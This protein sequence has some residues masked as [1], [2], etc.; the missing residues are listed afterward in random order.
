[1]SLRNVFEPKKLLEC[2]K[3]VKLKHPLIGEAEY[4][5]NIDS[6][7]ENLVKK[8]SCLSDI[9]LHK[10][11]PLLSTKEIGM[12]AYYIPENS[13]KIADISGI[14]TILRLRNTERYSSIL[15][16]RW[17]TYY[18]NKPCNLF[19]KLMAKRDSAMQ[20]ALNAKGIDFQRM[21]KWLDEGNIPMSIA[22]DCAL[23]ERQLP[24]ER[25]LSAVGIDS[26]K[27][28][29]RQ[30]LKSYY[31]ICRA[32][33]YLRAGEDM[34]IEIANTLLDEEFNMFLSNLVKK[35]SDEQL[36]SYH[37]LAARVWSRTEQV[38]R[39]KDFI[40][41]FEGEEAL[42]KKLQ[43]WMNGYQMEDMFLQA[44]SGNRRL[45]FWKRYKKNASYVY[46]DVKRT[47]LR[48][49][50]PSSIVIEF[51]QA[52]PLYFFDRQVYKE[53]IEPSMPR[54]NK[55]RAIADYFY[56][57]YADTCITRIEHH[58]VWETKVK[59]ALRRYQVLERRDPNEI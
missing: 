38:K 3:D 8:I 14:C 49:E 30:A 39:R 45:A 52:G 40:T 26:Q 41:L 1:M 22:K 50:F 25:K 44:E 24:I 58:G 10:E 27:T 6:T 5:V 18:Q 42:Q 16:N 34:L 36:D 7:L 13:L 33:D 54:T 35:L 46:H 53:Q 57:Q 23:D 11:A 2:I 37:A 31:L 17:E 19:I 12:L 43:G 9:E 55:N 48:M 20:A 47:L 51:S 28:L 15:L 21:I 29:G 32:D 4:D 59:Q 56:K